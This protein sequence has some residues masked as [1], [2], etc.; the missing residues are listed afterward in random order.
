MSQGDVMLGASA[1]IRM[2]RLFGV[3]PKRIGAE[4]DEEQRSRHHRNERHITARKRE[5]RLAVS[6]PSGGWAN[7]P[8][9]LFSEEVT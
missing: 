9:A 7:I 8:T 2:R 4:G 6:R 3:R 5:L 1:K